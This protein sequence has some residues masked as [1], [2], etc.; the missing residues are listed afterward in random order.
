MSST[1]Q[2]CSQEK[3]EHASRDMEFCWGVGCGQDVVAARDIAQVTHAIGV[4]HPEDIAGF[5][6]LRLTE[7]GARDVTV[8][9]DVAGGIKHLLG[10]GRSV[11]H[12]RERL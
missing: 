6:R 7:S 12:P 4:V 10:H 5:L 8:V 11:G 9:D 3:R 1:Y 2:S